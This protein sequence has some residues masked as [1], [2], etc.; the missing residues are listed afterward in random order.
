MARDYLPEALTSQLPAY[1]QIGQ[2][3]GRIPRARK[4]RPSPV[5]AT[6]P[7]ARSSLCGLDPKSVSAASVRAAASTW[8]VV[9]PSAAQSTV[10]CLERDARDGARDEPYGDLR[11]RAELDV[12]LH[13]VPIDLSGSSL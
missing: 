9:P 6:A 12:G 2:L 8:S 3:H 7:I 4:S 1:P 10:E 5:L 11:R 13:L